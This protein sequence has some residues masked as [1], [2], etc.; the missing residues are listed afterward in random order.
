MRRNAISIGLG[1]L[2]LGIVALL[3]T[4]S[5][6]FANDVTAQSVAKERLIATTRSAAVA[7][8]RKVRRAPRVAAAVVPA[9][10]PKPAPAVHPAVNHDGVSVH[11]R[12]IATSVLNALPSGCRDNLKNFSVL[13]A[14]A[15]RRGLGGK[16]TIIL[17]GSVPDAEF[18]ALLAHECGHVINGNL[19]GTEASGDSGYRDGPD[20]FYKDGPAVA[21]WSISWNATGT[22]KAGMKDADFVSGYAKSD[23]YEDFAETFAAYVLQR[24]MLR[25]RADANAVI[26]AKLAWM[27]THLPLAE[28]PLGD[29]TAESTGKVPW[30]IT[31]LPIDM[32]I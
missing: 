16:T 3:W 26:A 10:L 5:R 7:S 19:R 2:L 30:D 14:G 12:R 13:Y 8:S 25:A 24:D 6:S 23:Q 21:F 27:E 22:K 9:P 31:K 20:V 17:D 18:A 28:D 11:H 15:T 4:A 32:A 1:T 29:G